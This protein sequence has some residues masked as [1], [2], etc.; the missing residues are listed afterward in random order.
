MLRQM[1]TKLILKIHDSKQVIQILFH[2]LV[3]NM[4][5]Y[6]SK[7]GATSAKI[8]C[9]VTLIIL[10]TNAVEQKKVPDFRHEEKICCDREIFHPT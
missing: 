1:V 10:S 2:Q 9:A 5:K 3:V 4:G 8:T 6:F 7:K